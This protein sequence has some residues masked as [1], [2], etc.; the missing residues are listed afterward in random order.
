MKSSIQRA[1]S[2]N[3][4]GNKDDKD[5]MLE[6]VNKVYMFQIAIGKINN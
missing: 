6:L 4:I 5:D 2:T 1:G 3:A